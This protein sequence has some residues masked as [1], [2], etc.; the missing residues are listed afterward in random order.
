MFELFCVWGLAQ[1]Y[2]QL[3]I[4]IKMFTTGLLSLK[5]RL[6]VFWLH[7]VFF[8]ARRLSLVVVLY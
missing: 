5:E 7:W 8:A 2:V 1:M 6:C 3:P 4:L